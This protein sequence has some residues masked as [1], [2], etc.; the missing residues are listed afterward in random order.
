MTDLAF[1]VCSSCLICRCLA[2]ETQS[3]V[4]LRWLW[5]CIG[6]VSRGC[7]THNQKRPIPEPNQGRE[8]KKKRGQI[9]AP[10][11]GSTCYQVFPLPKWK[12]GFPGHKTSPSSPSHTLFLAQQFL[13]S[14]WQS[15]TVSN[16]LCKV[17]VFHLL[18]SRCVFFFW[19]MFSNISK[20]TRCLKE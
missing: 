17:H 16:P 11:P 19:S 15:N 8:H 12:T 9:L 4:C 13:N 7:A 14:F 18:T 1:R 6:C 2:W 20:S 10:V 5:H 3:R